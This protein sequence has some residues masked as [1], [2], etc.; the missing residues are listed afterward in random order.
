[1]KDLQLR[2]V[3]NHTPFATVYQLSF[4]QLK[5][6]L[7]SVRAFENGS[8]VSG[9]KLTSAFFFRY[10]P[11]F[12]GLH[13]ELEEE[14]LLITAVE[15]LECL[16]PQ[17]KHPFVHFVGVTEEDA[18]LLESIEQV[19]MLWNSPSLWNYIEMF[20]DELVVHLPNGESD[21]QKEFLTTAIYQKLAK[22]GL[23]LSDVP[24]LIPFFKEGGWP[25]QQDR[26]VGHL[27]VALRLNEPEEDSEEWLLETVILSSSSSKHWTPAVRKR[28]LPMN[29]A[30]PDKWK[31]YSEEIRQT[32]KQMLELLMLD[33]V[34]DESFL[35]MPLSDAEVR[36]LLRDKFVKLTALGFEVI[37]PGWLKE[38][39]K[40]KMRVRVNAQS[41][42]QKSMAGLDDI[43]SF[44][45]ELSI[46]GE[47]ISPE[48]FRKIVDE[49]REFIRIGNEWFRMDADWM[50][51]VRELMDKAEKENWTV[52]ELV[53]REIPE[54]L[55]NPSLEEEEDAEQDDPLFAF[56]MQRSLLAYVNQLQEKQGLP[57]VKLPK[58]LN[59]TLRPYQQQGFEWLVFM[60]NQQFGAILADDMGLGKT[61]QLISY[62]LHLY[63]VL[64]EKKP[65]LIVCPTSVLGNW[66]KELARFA[67]TLKVHTHYSSS[68][69]KD[70]EFHHFLLKESPQVVLSTYGTISQDVEFLDSIHWAVVT[71]DEAQNI[72]NMQT[73]QS[74]AIRRLHG[75][76]H[77]ALTGT[78]IENRLSEL[79]AIFDFIHRGYLGSFKKF[80]DEF[81]VPIEREDS[82][83]HKTRLRAK[84]RPFLLRRTKNDPELQLNL[85]DKQETKEFCPLTEEQAALYEGYIQESLAGLE[86]MSP[87]ERK[88]RILQMLSKLKQLCN[89]PALY[90]KEPFSDARIMLERS[91]KLKRIV[92]LT[93]E[94]VERGE[95][96][97]I[98][99]QYIGM[100]HLLQHCFFELFDWDVPFLTGSMRKE[101]RD[102]L[103]EAFQAGDFPIFL[104]SLKAG[105]TGL[106]LTAANHVLHA[107]RWWNPAVE[108]Q[109]TDRA[110]RIGQTQFVQVHKFITIGTI[111]EKV[112]Q[113][114][115]MKSALSAELIQSSQWL[116][117]LEEDKLMELLKLG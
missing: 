114:L 87:F 77:I 40:T 94:I 105:G 79:W 39:R 7:Y 63:E 9:E 108:N 55:L 48:E 99:T 3:S 29:E 8:V 71:L 31:N 62:V 25:L 66:Q 98:F 16:S 41:G 61:V 22:R 57:S 23:Q 109:A 70:E 60:R 5:Q 20:E 101:Q 10:E 103:V 84:I 117:E 107:D 43:L 44:R 12:Y 47:K 13:A 69:L 11:N 52:K 51:K 96:C 111:E 95:Q 92:E 64:R 83:Q 53:F 67:P 75:D 86:Q 81:I 88:G 82:D 27:K 38:L 32:Q 58:S 90:L 45:W 54:E 15:L 102:A 59:A 26:T 110:Y 68:R 106:N 34:S 28:H 89:H 50:A 100:G 74:K 116:T 30:L 115:E 78:P 35:H 85:P 4:E 18:L 49:K 14:A 76:H 112:D 56:E 6:G 1:M 21:L 42:S 97:L 19:Q 93:Q 33:N 17:F 113:M 2:K 46:G 72:K 80:Q 91:M 73:M 36:T 24:S 37:L 65:T 104:L